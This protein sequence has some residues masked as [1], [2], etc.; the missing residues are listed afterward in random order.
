MKKYIRTDTTMQFRRYYSVTV[1]TTGNKYQV[2]ATGAVEDD[3]LELRITRA[4][5]NGRK[6][7]A[8]GIVGTTAPGVIEV[9]NNGKLAAS[10]DFGTFADSSMDADTYL[11]ELAYR[12]TC[13]VDEE[14]ELAE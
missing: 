11:D 14:N 3:S 7:Y 5:A 9:W 8:I 12:A 2:V 4:I 1:E 13:M 6:S 10:E